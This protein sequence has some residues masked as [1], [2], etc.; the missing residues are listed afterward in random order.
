MNEGRFRCIEM[1]GNRHA[2]VAFARAEENENF[3]YI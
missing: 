3:L 1:L 2:C